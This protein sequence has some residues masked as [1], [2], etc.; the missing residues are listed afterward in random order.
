[1]AKDRKFADSTRWSYTLKP[2]VTERRNVLLAQADHRPVG[3]FV[4]T[5]HVDPLYLLDGPALKR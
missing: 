4:A 1:M 2:L 5:E 3:E